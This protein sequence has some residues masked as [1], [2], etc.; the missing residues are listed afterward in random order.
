MD[1]CVKLCVAK[2]RMITTLLQVN[3]NSLHNCGSQYY[4]KTC[5]ESKSYGILRCVILEYVDYLN[6]PIVLSIYAG[7][8]WK[9][10]RCNETAGR[11]IYTFGCASQD[12]RGYVFIITPVLTLLTLCL[13]LPPVCMVV[14]SDS[15]LGM[16]VSVSSPLTR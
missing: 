2:V 12:T 9:S 15:L 8:I 7:S 16:L 5:H 3:A 14:T 10:G 6:A 4:Q 11:H 1:T 13:S